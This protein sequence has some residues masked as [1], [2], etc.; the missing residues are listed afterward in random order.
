MQT[1]PHP[2]SDKLILWYKQHKRDL[3][4]RN[5][6]DAYKIWLS[7]IMLQQTQVAQGLNYYLKFIN[8]FDTVTQLAN[9]TEDKVLQMWQGLGYYSRARNLHATAKMIS[10][11][12]NGVFPNNYNEIKKLK[13][14]GDYTAAAIS[15][16][17]YNLPYAVVDGNVYRVLSRLFNINTPINSSQGKK[18]FQQLAT[19]ILNINTPSQHNNA[20]MEFGALQC[21]PKNPQCETCPLQTNCL[22]FANNTMQLLPVKDKKIK[23][24]NRYFNYIVFNY[25]DYLY[26]QKRT[27]KDIWQ[28]LFEFY[29]IETTTTVDE[30][31]L[32]NSDEFKKIS[33]AYE[34]IKTSHLKKHI[35]SHQHIYSTFYEISVAKPLIFE[36]FIKIKKSDLGNFALPQLIVKYLQNN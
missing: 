34:L 22:A 20:I 8:E 33:S 17:A 5:T 11:N 10:E 36:Q 14:I 9:A 16:I 21:K 2:I 6:T 12:Y 1:V 29:L 15:S 3:P 23:I 18:Y 4:W 19:E 31:T 30:K 7:E 24:K 13:G 26:I 32:L 25:K 28:N 27:E 35:L